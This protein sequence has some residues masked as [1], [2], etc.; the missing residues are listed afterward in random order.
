MRALVCDAFGPPETLSF[1]DVLRP[2]PAAGEVR[3]AVHAIAA[4]FPDLLIVGGKYQ[5]KPPFPFIPGIEVSGVV[6]AVG[7]DSGDFQPGDRV[8]AR[9]DLGGF[10]E[11]VCA[12]GRTVERMPEKM[13]FV[14]AAGFLVG[15]GTSF[16]GLVDRGNLGV[17]EYLLVLGA[18]GGVGLTAVELGKRIGA[19]VIAAGGSDEKLAVARE[20]GA[21]H[22]INYTR[23]NIRERVKELTG[24][25]GADVVYDPVGGDATDQ[26]IRAM[27]W[28]AR[29]LVVGF[30]SGR[31]AEIPANRCL[32]KNASAIGVFWGPYAER[33]PDA[34]QEV[35]RRLLTMYAN[36]ML[37]PK[38]SRVLPFEKAREALMAL[39]DRSVVGRTV[40]TIRN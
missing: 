5:L 36:D 31:I 30:S 7:V 3:I 12:P 37:R 18:T 2:E 1:R 34:A 11:Y 24:G 6:D 15:Y 26:A 14:D 28:G 32:I 20:Y 38:V 9:L 23:E 35:Y 4:N 39:S 19:V 27:A 33:N 13:S 25:H 16:H 8:M 17:G 40:V 10:A 21:D 22:L 29:F